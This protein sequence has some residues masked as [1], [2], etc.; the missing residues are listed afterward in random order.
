LISGIG[1]Q[2]GASSN[3][4]G[5]PVIY[6]VIDTFSRLIVGLNVSLEGPSWTGPMLGFNLK[7]CCLKCNEIKGAMDLH[8][9]LQYAL[10]PDKNELMDRLVEYDELINTANQ[11]RKEFEVLYQQRQKV[12]E[13]MKQG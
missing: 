11:I 5:R 8:S 2:N 10:K 3:I 1:S 6:A 13:C 9:F 4:I 7:C 12:V